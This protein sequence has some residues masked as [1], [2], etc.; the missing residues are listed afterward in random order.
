MKR[1]TPLALEL[2]L[3]AE[4]FIE[5]LRV[6]KDLGSPGYDLSPE[7]LAVLDRWDSSKIAVKA[8]SRPA[9]K[10]VPYQR[11]QPVTDGARP[12]QA[13]RLAPMAASPVRGVGESGV[14]VLFVSEAHI[15]AESEAGALLEKIALAMGLS[16]G[17]FKVADLEG[18]IEGQR[19]G[20]D[21][22]EAVNALSPQAVC[23]LGER[24]ARAVLGAKTPFPA[25]AGRF[26]LA[27]IGEVM[28]TWHPETILACRFPEEEKHVKGEVW[29]H[30]QV[31]MKRLG[32][33]VPKPQKK[34]SAD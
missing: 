20:A 33:S 23:V 29:K 8:A 3:L 2:L 21:L 22:A 12:R 24:A 16:G 11:V 6:Q 18:K 26:H 10:D 1:E 13:S 17:E 4:A 25:L 34:N 5:D 28:P 7:A 30:M 9:A 31:I 15:P 32:L 14:R 19:Q 27:G